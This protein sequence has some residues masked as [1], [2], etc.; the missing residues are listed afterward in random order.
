MTTTKY[1]QIL[2]VF[3]IVLFCLWCVVMVLSAGVSHS[4][5]VEKNYIPFKVSERKSHFVQ[6]G[7]MIWLKQGVDGYKNAVK[8]RFS[9]LGKVFR[10]KILYE[11]NI[12][13]RPEEAFLIKGVSDKQCPIN[14][15]QT[16]YMHDTI[17]VV[18]TGYDPYPDSGQ[19]DWAGTTFLGWR[20]RY[21]IAAVDPKVIPL[22]SLIYVD[23]YGFAWAGDTGGD[24]K[25]KRLDLCYNST[26]DALKWGRKKVKVY[27]LGKKPPVK[28]K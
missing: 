6:K 9:F 16:T 15:P 24:I 11:T 1:L 10:E 23:G 14:V 21:G 4:Y 7:W 18:A 5:S 12:L 17:P 26:E 8:E 19:L 25:G 20:A 28:K 2:K 3:T 27:V 22:R 13:K